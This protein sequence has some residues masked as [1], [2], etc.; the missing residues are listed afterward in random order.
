MRGAINSTRMESYS[1][2]RA[3]PVIRQYWPGK[4]VHY[5][6]NESAVWRANTIMTISPSAVWKAADEDIWNT[7]KK[8]NEQQWKTKWVKAH[9]D[10]TKKKSEWTMHEKANMKIDKLAD[11]QYD[12]PMNIEQCETHSES[13]PRGN[14][15]LGR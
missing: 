6:D 13:A 1:R 15:S 3:Q 14:P 12:T 4:V 9:V 10:R 2:L 11:L 8:Q 5:V 7:V